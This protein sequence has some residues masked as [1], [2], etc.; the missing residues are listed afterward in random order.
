MD[1]LVIESTLSDMDDILLAERS[2]EGENGTSIILCFKA[3]HTDQVVNAIESLNGLS[4]RGVDFVICKTLQ[5]G[6]YDLEIR[7]EGLD[8]PIRL[9]N[10]AIS[11]EKLGEI[12][13]YIHSD[14]TLSLSAN[15]CHPGNEIRLLKTEIKDCSVKS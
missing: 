8:E 15:V 6:L 1:R 14:T 3:S 9:M 2:I 7:C 10:K 11:N 12:E 4:N 13:D 5:S